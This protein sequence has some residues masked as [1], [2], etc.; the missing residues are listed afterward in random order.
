MVTFTNLQDA[1]KAGI[2]TPSEAAAYA[3]MPTRM[4]IRWLFGNASGEAVLEPQF[5]SFEERFVSFLDFVQAVAVRTIR[6]QYKV[7]LPK[8]RAGVQWAK[9]H[10]GIDY[11]FAR[12]HVAYLFERDL[13]ILPPGE[14]TAL[15]QAT[16]R[17]V[18]QLAEKRIVED[19]IK[20]LVFDPQTGLSREYVAAEWQ[21][22]RITMTP[23]RRFGEPVVVSCGIT[24]RTLWEAYQTEGGAEAAAEVFGVQPA[25]VESA[26]RYY[27]SLNLVEAK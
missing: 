2:Y 4:L 25:E 18:G 10:F 23:E 7:P 8:I 9:D 27:M 20:D 17:Q 1:L 13:F 24:A 16:G 19:Y 11:P 6:E 21:S 15:V 3:R 26:W 12:K 5:A 14:E 22:R